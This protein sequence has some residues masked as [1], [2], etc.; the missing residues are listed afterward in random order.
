MIIKSVYGHNL[1]VYET[2]QNQ[3][4]LRFF[5]NYNCNSIIISIEKG[6][7]VLGTFNFEGTARLRLQK[8]LEFIAKEDGKKIT[9][10]SNVSCSILELINSDKDLVLKL[11]SNGK[12]CEKIINR[13]EFAYF[14]SNLGIKLY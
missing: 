2:E 10:F 1:Y 8:M 3:N 4:D 14:L 13:D 5:V 9:F 11:Y 6:L 7:G 12:E